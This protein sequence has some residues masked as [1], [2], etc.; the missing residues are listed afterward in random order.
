MTRIFSLRPDIADHIRQVEA[1]HGE[2]DNNPAIRLPLLDAGPPLHVV[3][4]EEV[5]APAAGNIRDTL[6]NA[7]VGGSKVHPFCPEGPGGQPDMGGHPLVALR[8][9]T[10]PEYGY[11][12]S[13]HGVRFFSL[14]TPFSIVNGR[15]SSYF[16]WLRMRASPNESR[17]TELAGPLDKTGPFEAGEGCFNFRQPEPA[18]LC[19]GV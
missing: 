7:L 14:I 16:T 18:P 9:V 10:D 13:W 1:V 6:H 3:L 17:R 12:F 2:V 5:A 11:F 4:A 8:A 19:K 15:S